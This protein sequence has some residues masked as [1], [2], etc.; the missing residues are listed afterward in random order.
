MSER[1]ASRH[2][3][4]KTTAKGLADAGG[5]RAAVC[6]AALGAFDEALCAAGE[7][8]IPPEA[9]EVRAL[10]AVGACAG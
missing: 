7:A 2:L 6:A 9:R 8:R 5:I 10:L 3:V 4:G 1:G